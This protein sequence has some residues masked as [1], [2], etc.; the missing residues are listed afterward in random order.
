M[1]PSPA[2]ANIMRNPSQF[3]SDPDGILQE[4]SGLRLVPIASCET[5]SEKA[6]QACRDKNVHL[7]TG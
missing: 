7:L 5:Y 3:R 2:L 6:M 1:L 4:L